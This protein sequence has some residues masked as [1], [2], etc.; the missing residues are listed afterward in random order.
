VLVGLELVQ[1]LV[2]H[3]LHP[4]LRGV[5]WLRGW[6]LLRWAVLLFLHHEEQH[7]LPTNRS[8]R[9]DGLPLVP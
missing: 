2:L 8:P 3:L 4:L 6:R 1:W 7:L 5:R 9:L